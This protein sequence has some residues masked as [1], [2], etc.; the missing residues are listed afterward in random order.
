MVEKRCDEVYSKK[1]EVSMRKKVFLIIAFMTFLLLGRNGYSANA[2]G[3]CKHQ[4]DPSKMSWAWTE[5]YSECTYTMPCKL[6]NE[7]IIVPNDSYAVYREPTCLM[8]GGYVCYQSVTYGGNIY[9]SECFAFQEHPL[10]HQWDDGITLLPPTCTASGTKKQT[11]KR[12]G[13]EETKEVQIPPVGHQYQKSTIPS[14]CTQLAIFVYHCSVCGY[15]YTETDYSSRYASHQLC[16]TEVTQPSCTKNGTTLYTC[17]VCGFEKREALPKATGHDYVEKRVEPT[18]RSSGYTYNECQVCGNSL[19]TGVLSPLDHEYQENIVSPTC[20]EQ[21]YTLHQ[22]IRC[23]TSYKD[24]YQEKLRHNY[25]EKT[26]D[27]TC[28][29]YGYVLHQCTR[30]DYSYESNYKPALGHTEQVKSLPASCTEN[31]YDLHSCIRCDWSYQDNVVYAAGHKW[32]GGTVT[33]SPTFTKT[34]MKTYTCSACKSTKT[35]SIAK[36]TKTT[37]AKAAVTLAKTS[38]VYNGKAQKPAV[39]VKIG[40][41]TVP[42]SQYTVTYSAN[43]K[44]G[45]AK[46]TINAVSKAAYVSGSV[47]KI[48]KITKAANPMTVSLASKSFTVAACKKK[49]QK[50]TIK[51]SKAQ[52]TVSYKSSNTKYV[53]V[54]TGKVTIKKGTPKGTYKIIVTAKGNANYNSSVKY[55]T[56]IV[57]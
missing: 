37:L 56:I 22:C 16:V 33:R 9:M 8:S 42:A 40:T 26:F 30:C 35:E 12:A 4:L 29:N 53:T 54:K 18:C 23:N 34:G 10:G 5:D 52:G 50:L 11:C 46:V 36:L 20:E 47:T 13:C 1:E 27:P 32:N 25:C 17:Q 15:E 48:F 21:G 14:T 57:K 2:V 7:Q 41:V 51:V 24:T 6:C 38:V 3:A 28:E 43:T 45:T 49:A 39:T 55:V 31:G 44:V 19:R